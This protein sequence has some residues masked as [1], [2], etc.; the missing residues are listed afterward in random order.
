MSHGPSA[1]DGLVRQKA[2]DLAVA[3]VN[4]QGGIG[5][6]PVVHL[7]ARADIADKDSLA[8]A[9]RELVERCPDAI[10]LGYTLAARDDFAQVFAAP[11]E[12]GCPV[13]HTATSASARQ[14]VLDEPTRFGN[15]FQAC[16]PEAHYGHGFV[17]TLDALHRRGHWT[18]AR[19]HLLVLDSD[20]PNLTTFT[21]AAAAHA[22]RS[23][24]V[25][26]LERVNFLDPDWTTV[27]ARIAAVEP[28]AVMI[29]TWLPETLTEFL[30]LLDAL[31]TRPLVYAIYAPSVPG[32]LERAGPAA[33]GLLWATVI[34]LYQDARGGRFAHDFANAHRAD[35]GRSGAGIHYD[36]VHLLADAWRGA[37]NPRDFG[38]V[39]RRM[40]RI[41]HRGVSG[42]Y[43][44][45]SPGQSAHTY[46]D[47]TRDPSIAQA[48]LVHQVQSGRHVILAP[49]PYATGTFRPPATPGP[50]RQP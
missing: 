27:R 14:L 20:D 24:W 44:F 2:T 16:A 13:L 45:G 5:G 1:A 18:P 9:L 50:P 11:A 4:A 10:T 32:F 6:R 3:E 17:R 28:A 12:H 42:A 49:G 25:P 38:A 48:H 19:R 7:A 35:S 26:R 15:V 47:D 33:E 36:M 37:G 21:A 31:P 39:T 8:R 46:P 41:V 22:E 43:Y 40:R 29:A 23:G 30:R 34:G